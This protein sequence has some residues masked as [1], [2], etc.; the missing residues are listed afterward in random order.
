MALGVVVQGAALF[1]RH[2]DHLAL[3]LLG[4]LA[5]GLGDLLGLA[6]AKADTAFL[7]AHDDECGEAETLTTLD[8]LGHTVD[9]HQAIGKFGRLF[10]A[11]TTTAAAATLV[12]TFCHKAFLFS[13]C[14]EHRFVQSQWAERPLDHRGVSACK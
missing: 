13:W 7:V 2:A 14:Q 8:G 4:G 1:Q 5:D 3:G 11:V 10:F 12:V 9:R 6:L